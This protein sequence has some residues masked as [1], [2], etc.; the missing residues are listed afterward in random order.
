[1]AVRPLNREQAWL[2]PPT[3]DEL[4][5]ADH[6]A[7]FVAEF[8]DALDNS[9]WTELEVELGGERMGAPCYHARGLLSVWLYGFMTGVRSTRGLERAC[10]DQIPYLWLMGMQ[11]PDHNTLWRFYR[12]HRYAMR[13]LLKETVGTA[14]TMGLLTLAVQAV[15]GTKVAASA[16][17]DRTFDAESL[18]RLLARTEE[19]IREL[20]AQNEGGQEAVDERLPKELATA[21]ALRGK[22]K[23]AMAQLE[24]QEGLER[25]NLTDADAK[26]MKGGQGFLTGYNAQAMVSPL[27]PSTDEDPGGLLITA[28]DVAPDSHDQAQLIPMMEQAEEMTGDKAQV[29]LADAGYHSGENLQAC[30]QRQVLMAESQRRAL[31]HPYHKDRFTYETETDSYICPQGKQLPFR[32]I[33][34]TRGISMRVYR[35]TGVICRACPAFGTCTKDG[36]HGR[37]LE[38]GPYDAVLRSHRELMSTEQAKQA[39]KRRKELP[40]PVFGQLKEQQG[41]RQFLL[42]GL[43]HV[44]AEWVLLVTAFNLR[45]LWRTWAVRGSRKWAHVWAPLAITTA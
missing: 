4:L 19:A 14:A 38:I 40:E 30:Y 45:T 41:A 18:A 21:E 31:E 7:R 3:L 39:Y 28:A 13:R 37:A 29:T 24:G 25:I 16:A 9:V 34:K 20:E 10:R 23:H 36:R 12:D 6:P 5:A 32:R 15:D 42:R 35:A 43:A 33:K 11:Q 8:V 44:S 1:M 27:E 17:T 2:M 22:I 26:L